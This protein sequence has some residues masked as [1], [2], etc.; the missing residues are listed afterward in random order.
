M[1]FIHVVNVRWF[2]ATAWY[3][4]NLSLTLKEHGHDVLVI[5]LPGSPPIIRAKE[6]GLDSFEIDLNSN[7]PLKILENI[8]VMKKLIKQYNPDVINC[9]R[10]EFFWWFAMMKCMKKINCSLIRFRGDMRKPKNDLLNRVLLH[11]CTTKIVASCEKIAFDYIKLGIPH[12]KIHVIYGGIDTKKFF[13]DTS[14]RKIVRDELGFSEGDFLIG[15]IGRFDHVKGHEI[16]IKAV[17]KLYHENLMPDVKLIIA[18]VKAN[19]TEDEIRELVAK[20][21][22]QHITRIIGFRDD[23]SSVI[24]ALNLGVVASTGSETICRVAMEIMAA[25]VPVVASNVGALPEVVPTENIF[26]NGDVEDLC[27]KV[28]NHSSKVN[29]YTMKSFYSEYMNLVKSV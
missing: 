9:H 16:L 15:I 22:I 17:A 26:I 28:I 11:R 14:K 21:N 29:I 19:I 4:V 8:F 18:G 25:G 2:N 1:R 20:N 23:I 6:L 13:K 10:G 27:A 5:G 7:N 3:A 12:E 24:N